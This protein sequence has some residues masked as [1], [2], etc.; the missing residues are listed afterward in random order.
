LPAARVKSWP[1]TKLPRLVRGAEFAPNCNPG[2]KSTVN[3]GAVCGLV[4]LNS[5]PVN[6]NPLAVVAKNDPLTANRAFGPKIMPLGLSKNRLALPNTP[7]VPSIVEALPPVTRLKIFC[8][9][10]GLAKYTVPPV[11]TFKSRKLWNRFTPRSAPP[12]MSSVFGAIDR[13]CDASFPSVPSGTICACTGGTIAITPTAIPTLSQ[14]FHLIA[15]RLTL[16]LKG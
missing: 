9:A 2:V 5:L 14:P 8:T 6:V 1:A 3:K 4:A 7:S 15:I 10:V 11:G 13:T 16:S 12:S